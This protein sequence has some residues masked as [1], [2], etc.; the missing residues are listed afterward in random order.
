M[1]TEEYKIFVKSWLATN[2]MQQGKALKDDAIRQ[3]FELLRE[4]EFEEVAAAVSRHCRRSEWMPKPAN[5]IQILE[6]EV[7]DATTM[8]GLA[9]QA[10]TPLGVFVRAMLGQDLRQLNSRDSAARVKMHMHKITRFVERGRT[11]SYTNADIR[12]LS[13]AGVSVCAPLCDGLPGPR[14]VTHER[15]KE[16]ANL[17]AVKVLTVTPHH[18]LSPEQIKSNKA[19]ADK[20]L[21]GLKAEGFL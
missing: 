12:L 17:L 14:R 1:K 7:P 10:V 15:L 18:E 16:R 8:V 3:A 21:A 9:L 13:G 20:A 4:Y 6:G 5:I 2:D 11:A 19:A